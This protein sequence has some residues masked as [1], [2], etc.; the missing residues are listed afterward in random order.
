MSPGGMPARWAMT[1]RAA[2]ISRVIAA[3]LS[4]LN[5]GGGEA[6]RRVGLRLIVKRKDPRHSRHR[7][8]S[9][10]AAALLLPHRLVRQRVVGDFV[11]LLVQAPHQPPVCIRGRG[12]SGAPAEQ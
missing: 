3:V 10:T 12:G 6:G 11:A 1:W 7:Q 2:T 9:A 4:L 5:C 8:R